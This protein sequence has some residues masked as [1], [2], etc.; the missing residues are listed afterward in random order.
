MY[1]V[2]NESFERLINESLDE[3]PKSY[4]ERLDNVAITFEDEPDPHQRT[5]L[6]LRCHQTLYGLYEGIPRTERGS[7]YNLVLP[8]KI[9]LFKLPIE[10]S[11]HDHTS[12]KAQIKNTLWHEIAHHYGLDHARIHQLE[13]KMLRLKKNKG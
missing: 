8:D 11:S 4:I 10:A 6:K 9:T 12:L 3:L 5:K 2:D 7:S 13:S 1:T